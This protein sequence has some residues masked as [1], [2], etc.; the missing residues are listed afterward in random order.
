VERLVTFIR[1]V[2][3]ICDSKIPGAIVECGVWRGGSAMAALLRLVQRGEMNREVYLYDTFSGMSEPG[4]EDK[5]FDGIA[6]SSLLAAEERRNLEKNNWC[7][8]SREDVTANVSSTGYPFDLVKLIEGKVEQTIPKFCPS[9]I[10]ILRLDTDWYESTRHE[11]QHLMPKLNSK[12]IL[13][14]D[15]YGHWSGAKKATDEYFAALQESY[16]F[17]RIDYTGRLIMKV[18]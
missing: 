7:V 6:A 4:D 3:Y 14:I 17:H 12:G 18:G 1:S 8:A 5:R 9:S 15:D 11:L 13:I 2:D 10:A 16:F